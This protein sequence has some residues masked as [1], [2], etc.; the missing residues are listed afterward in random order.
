MDKSINN[1]FFLR[2]LTRI[3]EIKQKKL[4][5]NSIL[6]DQNFKKVSYFHILY[7]IY[8]TI[9]YTNYIRI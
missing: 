3:I 8:K 7:A 4:C 6:N 5:K 1:L 9:S 2:E